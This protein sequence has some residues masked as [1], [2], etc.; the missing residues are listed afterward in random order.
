VIGERNAEIT[1]HAATARV[2]G[3]SRAYRNA[4]R[5]AAVSRTSGSYGRNSCEYQMR[6]GLQAVSA[7]AITAPRREISFSPVRKTTGTAATPASA[8]S[9]RSDT[10]P[11]PN[12]RPHTHATQ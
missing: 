3:F 6:N 7:A 2:V 4:S 10:S 11:K 5:L 8:G 12:T 1:P 9:E